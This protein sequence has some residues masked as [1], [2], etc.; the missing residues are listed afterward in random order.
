MFGLSECYITFSAEDGDPS[1]MA[2]EEI[3]NLAKRYAKEDIRGDYFD[4]V[5]AKTEDYRQR[6]IGLLTTKVERR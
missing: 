4:T 6:L 3:V 2:T 1:P 5:V